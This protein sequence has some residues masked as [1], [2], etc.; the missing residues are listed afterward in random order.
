MNTRAI[1]VACALVLVGSSAVAEPSND[2][3]KPYVEDKGKISPPESP[4]LS[5]KGDSRW[6]CMWNN[7]NTLP[8]FISWRFHGG[9]T[10]NYVID[11]RQARR[12]FIGNNDGWV[13]WEYGEYFGGKCP[14]ASRVK[15]W[16]GNCPY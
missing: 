8:L 9:S 12:I 11:P 3:A 14:N 16:A 4:D 15:E 10:N 7:S 6:A 1:L 5:L 2:D 13:C